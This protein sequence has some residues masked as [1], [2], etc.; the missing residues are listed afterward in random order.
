MTKK[1]AMLVFSM[2]IAAVPLSAQQKPSLVVGTFTLASGVNWPY[3]MKQMQLQTITELKIK[4]GQTFE[5][6]I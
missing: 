1:L 4:D 2:A 6:V 5:V 3:D